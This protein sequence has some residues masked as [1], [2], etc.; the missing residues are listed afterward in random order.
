VP[1]STAV[2]RNAS[3][4]GSSSSPTTAVLSAENDGR[5]R[6][7]SSYDRSPVP[8]RRTRPILS[9]CGRYPLVVFLHG[10]RNDVDHYLVWDLVAAQ[11]ARSGFVVAVPELPS[12]PPFG[13]TSNPT[14]RWSTRF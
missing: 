13:G 2:R 9:G 11:L 4:I 10:Q 3:A 12:A 7:R 5:P 1:V 14:S 8:R 6:S